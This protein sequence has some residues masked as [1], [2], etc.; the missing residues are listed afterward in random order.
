MFPLVPFSPHC[1]HN[2]V[3]ESQ[4]IMPSQV[5]INLPVADLPKS[6]EYFRQLGYT[7]NTQFSDD[8]AACLVISEHI[9]AMILTHEKFKSFITT[10]ISNAKK[11]TEVLIALNQDSREKVN[12]IAG[13]AL[14]AGGTAFS[15]P[16][17]YGFMYMRTI[18]D[19]DGH[20]WEY[21]WMDPSF[22]QK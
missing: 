14:A 22:V 3:H 2:N 21:F 1:F 18:Q 5:F 12:E 10:E 17:D 16:K 11:Q 13:K 7:F 19:L 9:F 20:V 6:M 4:R 15:E 8:T